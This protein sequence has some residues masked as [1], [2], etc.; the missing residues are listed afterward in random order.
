MATKFP[1]INTKVIAAYV[2]KAAERS[3]N[4]GHPWIFE[5]SIVKTK[6]VPKTGDTIII[7]G[8]K[9]NKLLAVGLWDNDSMIKIKILSVKESVSLDGLFFKARIA[10]AYKKRIPLFSIT[11][12]YRL[13]YGENDFLPGLIADIYEDIVVIKLYTLIWLPYLKHICE[14]IRIKVENTRAIVLRFSRL[15]QTQ[16]SQFNLNEGM[17]LEGELTEQEVNI[18]ESGVQFTVNVIK[19]HKTGFFLDHR[20]N[21]IEIGSLSRNKKVLDVFCY[22]GGFSIHA[23]ASGAKEVHSVDISEQALKL[24]KQNS[25]SNA[26][27][28]KH[29]CIQKDAF[30]ALGEL[31]LKGEKFDIIVIDPPAFAKAKSEIDTALKQY[32]RLAK[33]GAQLIADQGILLLA[34]C[35]SRINKT[36]FREAV[37]T[38]LSKIDR[39]YSVYKETT[40]DI[41][42]P[43]LIPEAAY[44]KSIYYRFD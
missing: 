27:K 2:S 20:K 13:I 19:G 6:Q 35:S 14:A 32:E 37:E 12:A 33:L 3:I 16:I 34:S 38:G 28:G 21:R 39:R 7:Y 15:T 10:A 30:D 4:N 31:I 41:D 23:L 11:N 26:Y 22:A 8:K 18:S 25:E 24:A 5:N 44:L 43:I 9:S 29:I 36:E 17:V 40:H 1:T 42:H